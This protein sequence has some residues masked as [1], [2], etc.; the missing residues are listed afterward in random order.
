M[1]I[2]TDKTLQCK[3][4]LYDYLRMH[5]ER[6]PD[7]EYLIT[8][9]EVITY[10]QGFGKVNGLIKSFAAVGVGKGSVVALRAT[11]SP[12]TVLLTIALGALGATVALTDPHKAVKD[13]ISDCG[14]DIEPRFYVTDEGGGACA[15]GWRV[16]CGDRCKDIAFSEGDEISG[17]PQGGGD[18]PFMIIFT[19][20]S[21]GKAKAVVLSHKNCIANPV[22][23]MPLF[24]QNE[25]DRA[26]SILPLDHVFGFAV[27]ACATFCGHGAVFPDS[28]ERDCV[29][30]CLEKHKITVIYAVPS[31]YISLLGGIE[32]ERRKRD[33]SSL[34]LGLM[35]GAPFTAQ[36][37]K[38]IESR[39]GLRLMPGYGMSECVGIS[40]MN[41]DASVE[42]RA[43]GV[44]RLY[45]MTEVR[46][47]PAGEICVR[48][49]T[50]M[51]GYYNDAKATEEAIDGD[52]FLHTGDLGYLDGDGFLHV[53]GRIKDIIIRNG[54]NISA[55]AV[56]KKL[57]D[58]GAKEACVVG[59]ADKAAGEVPCALIVSER[60][61]DRTSLK[62]ALTKLEMP[63]EIK[64][65]DKIPLTPSGKPDKQRV[66]A[67]FGRREDRLFGSK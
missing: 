51:L 47:T 16:E 46:F 29:L 15:N 38:H 23:A 63:V 48:G 43:V 28:V 7:K 55:V 2:P 40:T 1:L 36:Q 10:A 65:A 49:A 3:L 32:N 59:V 11:R 33:L 58:A 34:R 52:G 42:E 35:A 66:R 13:F 6:T 26:I 56:E 25:N 64:Y 4:S 54:N 45:P 12:Q 53:S 8:D 57:L 60:E 41:Y 62:N 21:T 39:L 17:M 31:F 22:D 30:D 19:S 20:G 5:A 9:R 50:L 44:G 37:L 61:L 24:K 14:V 67:L 27:A 18:D